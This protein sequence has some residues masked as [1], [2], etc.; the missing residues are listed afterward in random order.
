MHF[1]AISC[2]ARMQREKDNAGNGNRNQWK[3]DRTVT[4]DSSQSGIHGD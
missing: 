1:V 2:E 4:I 3:K